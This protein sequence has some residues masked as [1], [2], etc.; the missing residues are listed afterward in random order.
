MKLIVNIFLASLLV[1]IVFYIQGASAIG[2]LVVGCGATII[3]LEG[4]LN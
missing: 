4:F 2:P 3:L 1:A